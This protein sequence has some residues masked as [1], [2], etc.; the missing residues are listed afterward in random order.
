MHKCIYCGA[1][2][3]GRFCNQCGKP[4]QEDKT[5]PNCGTSLKGGA[6]FCSEC[7]YSF[8]AGGM[9][10]SAVTKSAEPYS[11][12][13]TA[14]GLLRVLPALL[15]ILFSLLAFAFFAAP[16]IDGGDIGDLMTFAMSG[17]DDE[18]ETVLSVYTG[19]A[20]E[21]FVAASACF[22]SCGIVGLCLAAVMFLF[23]FVSPQKGARIKL[24]DRAK[25]PVFT[26]LPYVGYVFYFAFFLLGCIVAG[27]IAAF[28]EGAG[29]V[30]AGAGP[31][32]FIVFPILFGLFSAA[33]A[34]ARRLIGKNYPDWKLEEKEREEE[35]YI[36]FRDAKKLRVE[37]ERV[38]AEWTAAYKAEHP[39]PVPPSVLTK[40]VKPRPA[41]VAE[42]TPEL[43][44]AVDRA[45]RKKRS[46]VYLAFFIPLTI[47]SWIGAMICARIRVGYKPEK[48]VKHKWLTFGTWLNL[49]W[50]L[51]AIL[52]YLI[53][54]VSSLSDAIRWGDTSGF[55]G[56]FLIYGAILIIPAIYFFIMFGIAKRRIRM[57]RELIVRMYGS[58][59]PFSSPQ[60]RASMERYRTDLKNYELAVAQNNQYRE[61]TRAALAEYKLACAK[62]EAE[63]QRRLREVLK[64]V[65][66]S[67]E[68]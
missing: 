50:G 59:K 46:A 40:P 24:S 62:Y 2:F 31:I 64:S 28:D 56:S 6:K 57:M 55:L 48:V 67:A 10:Q 23:T 51:I 68:S 53:M 29:M 8:V 12:L 15:F 1:E 3:E 33:A 63:M 36:E 34:V 21:T 60:Y 44:I 43:E 65:R 19:L 18:P 9:P 47:F 54:A 20:D 42:R 61:E 16:L 32:L 39:E 7:G 11:P 14:Y 27:Q 66:I 30:K 41:V 38:R 58:P 25:P 26:V 45:V 17:F 4:R 52:I 13:K 22:L 49:F 5:C 37:R 35:N